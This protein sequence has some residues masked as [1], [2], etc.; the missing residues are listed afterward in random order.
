MTHSLLIQNYSQLDNILMLNIELEVSHNISL[1][2]KCKTLKIQKNK[3]KQ[4]HEQKNTNL[5]PVKKWTKLMKSNTNLL[6]YFLNS[7]VRRTAQSPKWSQQCTADPP[8]CSRALGQ[9]A[10]GQAKS[11]FWALRVASKT[12]AAA[13]MSGFQYQSCRDKTFK[14]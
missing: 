14:H 10:L 4:N 3:T 1:L 12:P 7:I 9:M 8:S 2:Q 11:F 13:L 5:L 6:G